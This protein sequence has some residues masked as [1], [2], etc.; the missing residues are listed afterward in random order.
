MV[1]EHSLEHQVL[2]NLKGARVCALFVRPTAVSKRRKKAF[3][4]D[5]RNTTS[6]LSRCCMH[7]LH[8]NT[9][10]I[11]MQNANEKY[12]S[13][14]KHDCAHRSD[15]PGTVEAPQ[16]PLQMHIPLS[17]WKLMP[18]DLFHWRVRQQQSQLLAAQSPEPEWKR[19]IM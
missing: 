1:Q 5:P 2:D 10:H 17:H 6:K 9:H 14:H 3:P 8:G 15:I 18:T 16:R 19:Q 13:R 7:V 11:H 4:Q 12:L